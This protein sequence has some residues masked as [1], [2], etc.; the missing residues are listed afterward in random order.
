M[1]KIIIV[2]NRLKDGYRRAGI[3]L[4][5]GDNTFSEEELTP[6]QLHALQ[7]DPRLS[8]VLGAVE[9]YG[10]GEGLSGNGTG[11][12]TESEM[13][14]KLVP[15]N[16]TIEQ[17]KAKLTDLHVEFTANAKKAELVALLE[18]ALKSE[19]E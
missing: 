9:N 4:S 16:L 2:K 3:A 5:K 8:V 15:A 10:G 1:S 19:G 7:N 13:D 18:S 17:L 6:S 11:N 14:D 12:K